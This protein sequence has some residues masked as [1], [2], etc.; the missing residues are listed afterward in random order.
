MKHTERQRM[1]P[2]GSKRVCCAR[3]RHPNQH[4]AT[5]S[6]LVA[7]RLDIYIIEILELGIGVN[8]TQIKGFTVKF[9]DVASTTSPIT[10]NTTK[11]WVF[12][13]VVFHK[14][15]TVFTHTCTL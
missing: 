7:M 14:L 2:S 12:L 13:V 9:S 3:R 1:S 8:M 15:F 5:V 6:K 11:V 10:R 4:S